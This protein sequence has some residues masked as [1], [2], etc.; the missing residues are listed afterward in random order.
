MSPLGPASAQEP[1][2]LFPAKAPKLAWG[3][4]VPVWLAVREGLNSQQK[5]A[6]YGKRREESISQ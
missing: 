4:S 5:G 6:C 1:H 2:P 3:V